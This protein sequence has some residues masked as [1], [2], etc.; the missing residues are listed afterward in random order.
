MPTTAAQIASLSRWIDAGSTGRDA[1]AVTWGRLAKVSEEQGEVIAAYIG[2]T[3]QNPRKGV[4][5]TIDDV[6]EELLDVALT[7][8]A[9][10]EHLRGAPGDSLA[11]LDAKVT[12]V[13]DRARP[14]GLED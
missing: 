7:A 5:H 8:L 9:A 6:V 3:G 4:T 13:I 12:A 11:L 1:E 2:A 14:H 10:V